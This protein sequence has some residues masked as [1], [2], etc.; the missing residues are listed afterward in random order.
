MKIFVIIFL[1]VATGIIFSSPAYVFAG[2]INIESVLAEA[3]FHLKLERPEEAEVLFDQVL[4]LEQ[5][6]MRALEGKGMVLFEMG[7][8]SES[9]VFFDKVLEIDPKNIVALNHKGKLRFGEGSFDFAI[10]FFNQTLK[11]DPENVE[12]K[13]GM[14]DSLLKI[15]KHDEAFSYFEKILYLE[16]NYFDPAGKPIYEKILDLKPTHQQSLIHMG[17][18]LL[19]DGEMQ[20]GLEIFEAVLEDEQDN[21]DGLIGKGKSL[22]EL[23]ELEQSENYFEKVLKIDSE[24]TN[25]LSGLGRIY[26][27]KEDS[28]NSI[29]YFDKALRIDSSHAE[30][31]AGF[32]LAAKQA[33]LFI[34][35]SDIIH[36]HPKY[37][38]PTESFVELVVRDKDGSLITYQRKDGFSV[39]NDPIASERIEKWDVKGHAVIDG[40]NYQILHH[41]ITKTVPKKEQMGHPGLVYPYSLEKIWLT[42]ARFELYE[43]HPGDVVTQGFTMYKLAN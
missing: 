43:V 33:N 3:E 22:I 28:Q 24:N 29:N 40:K 4:S 39:L 23:G 8:F 35:Q 27:E 7:R 41:E 25:A 31:R 13:N 20:K 36:G 26:L 9:E 37:F 38:E 5:Q 19:K 18:S 6:N 16:P 42:F 32:T 15:E 17:N 1:T 21:I 2:A 30:S 34:S 10:S 12:A 11:V 14:G